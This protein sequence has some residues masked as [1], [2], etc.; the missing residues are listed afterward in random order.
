MLERLDN[1]QRRYSRERGHFDVR[2]GLHR[3]IAGLTV[4]Q[5][6]VGI[7]GIAHF[8]AGHGRVSVVRCQ[9]GD[10]GGRAAHSG[11][12]IGRH[13]EL[14]KQHGGDAGFC[15]QTL[16]TM[17]EHGLMR[18]FCARDGASSISGRQEKG[19]QMMKF[20]YAA[21]TC[22]LAPHAVACKIVAAAAG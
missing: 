13:R 20:Y 7:A 22:A 2:Q 17:R 3:L 5:T 12:C 8:A 16:Y 10:D 19:I 4:L 1:R 9:G 11:A 6:Q 21:H 18:G 14:G 15:E